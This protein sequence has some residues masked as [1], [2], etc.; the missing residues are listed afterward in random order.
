MQGEEKAVDEW[1][2]ELDEDQMALGSW[3]IGQM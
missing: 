1:Q 3:K 2:M